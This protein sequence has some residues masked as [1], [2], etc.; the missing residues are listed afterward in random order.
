MKLTPQQMDQKI[1]E[2]FRFEANDDVAGVL[3]TLA[4]GATHDIVGYPTGPTQDRA[5]I[6]AFYEGLFADLSEGKVRSLKR[7][8]GDNF[9]VDESLWEGRAP[10]RP[11]G[12]DGQN[13]PLSFR[14]LHVVE[15]SDAGQIKKEQVWLDM[16]AIMQ[17][18]QAPK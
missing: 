14:L 13:R 17:Q 7:L 4:P 5:A 1:D 2:H 15:F 9:M 3:T 6:K 8:Y 11:F 16:M 10:G 12:M 18:L